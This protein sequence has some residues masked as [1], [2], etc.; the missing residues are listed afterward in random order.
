MSYTNNY[1]YNNCKQKYVTFY[2]T[3]M[4]V[5][6]TVQYT[7]V[8]STRC[9]LCKHQGQHIQQLHCLVLQCLCCAYVY[10]TDSNSR[11]GQL[12]GAQCRLK[13]GNYKPSFKRV[14]CEENKKSGKQ[15]ALYSTVSSHYRSFNLPLIGTLYVTHAARA[16]QS[17]DCRGGN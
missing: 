14:F 5:H 9:A 16:L 3:F 8:Y 15:V 1:S 13:A 17:H 12:E 7:E 2:I 6:C 4:F 11:I 10:L